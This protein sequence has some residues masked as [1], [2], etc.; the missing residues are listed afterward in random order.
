MWLGWGKSVIVLCFGNE[1]TKNL[2]RKIERRVDKKEHVFYNADNGVVR[3]YQISGF[4][5]D[6]K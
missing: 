1:K 6:L 3:L 5:P 2:K 4:C